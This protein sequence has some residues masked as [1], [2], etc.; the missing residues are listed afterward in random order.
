M[1]VKTAF[2]WNGDFGD[3]LDV[4]DSFVHQIVVNLR[5]Q[6]NIGNIIDI[7]LTILVHG[8]MNYQF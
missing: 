4:G 6:Y 5:H 8:Q 3:N 7:A 1:I 2:W